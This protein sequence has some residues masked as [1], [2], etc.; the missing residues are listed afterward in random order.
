LF[1]QHHRSG[2][3]I[4]KQ[5]RHRVSPLEHQPP[6][7]GTHGAA[8]LLVRDDEFLDQEEIVEDATLL[9]FR[10]LSWLSS[11]PEELHSDR[12]AHGGGLCRQS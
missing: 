12:Q 4:Q 9:L 1:D 10:A 6:L 3:Q 8:N 7:V 2:V 11:E 5:Y